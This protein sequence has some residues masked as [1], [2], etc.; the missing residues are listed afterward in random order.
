MQQEKN[1][2]Q[3]VAGDTFSRLEAAGARGRTEGE[4]GTG[5]FSV[6]GRAEV[7]LQQELLGGVQ[8]AEWEAMQIQTADGSSKVSL[9]ITISR[10]NQANN[11][12]DGV[13]DEYVSSTSLCRS[14]LAI[15]T[16]A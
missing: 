9:L 12:L 7:E 16:F 13:L 5:P 4:N 15:M 2:E 8:Q 11:G 14:P 10:I 6:A 1:R 3:R